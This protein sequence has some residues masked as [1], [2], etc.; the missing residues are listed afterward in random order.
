[1]TSGIDLA[2]TVSLLLVLLVGL[3]LGG[4]AGVLWAR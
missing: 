4:A 1:M 2:T 3:L